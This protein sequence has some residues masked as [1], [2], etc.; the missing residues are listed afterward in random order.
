MYAL[1]KKEK[2][3]KAGNKNTFMVNGDYPCSK[4]CFGFGHNPLFY[5]T[6]F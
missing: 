6:F 2:E 5:P 3:K 4:L 1:Q